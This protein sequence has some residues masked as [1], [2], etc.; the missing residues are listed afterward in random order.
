MQN[1]LFQAKI[2]ILLSVCV[3]LQ[4][5]GSGV[6]ETGSGTATEETRNVGAFNNLNIEGDYEIVLQEG[7]NPLVTVQT[8]ENLHQYIE[9]RL[10]GNTLVIRDLE[11]IEPTETTRLIITYQ[12]IEEI[13]LGG[14]AKVSNRGVLKAKDLDL[15]ID[16]AAVIDLAL[17]AEEL[18]VKIAGAGVVTLSG[19]VNKQTVALSGA[20]NLDSYELKSKECTIELSGIGSAQVFASSSLNA[21]VS[22]VGNIR[23]KGDP[24]NIKREVSGLGDIEASK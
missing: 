17:Q 2:F 1:K 7:T 6:H 24:R 3:L 5:C 11:K 18:E 21:E 8:D 16:G 20:G 14:S 4:A 23:F 12:K 10:D 22:G 9:T 19:E 15:R 13:K